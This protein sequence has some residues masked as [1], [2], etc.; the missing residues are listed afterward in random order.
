M[1]DPLYI[2]KGCQYFARERLQTTALFL[3]LKPITAFQ[4][5][6]LS[7]NATQ[8]NTHICLGANSF[9][10]FLL[11]KISQK[12]LE[13]LFILKSLIKPRNTAP[14]VLI[15]NTTT[16]TEHALSLLLQKITLI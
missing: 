2:N 4:P 7:I 1:F 10:L 16:A 3:F 11:R 14:L 12:Y 8:D 9:D 5:C 6:Y 13:R 15:E